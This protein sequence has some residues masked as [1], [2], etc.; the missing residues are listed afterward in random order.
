MNRFA[1]EEE[2]EEKKMSRLSFSIP[3]IKVK[4]NYARINHCFT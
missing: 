4:K 2:E 3:L 1:L